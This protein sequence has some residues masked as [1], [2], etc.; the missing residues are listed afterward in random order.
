MKKLI[1]LYYG[2][3]SFIMNSKIKRLIKKEKVD[4]Y[5]VTSYD[6]EE[7][8]I[9]EAINDA[10][11]I[12]FLSD[13][14]IIIIN[15]CTFL[16][17]SYKSKDENE[18]VSLLEYIN[19]PVDST[20]LIFELPS[21]K[22]DKRNKIVKKILDVAA[23]EECKSIEKG[24]LTSWI[25]KQLDRNNLTI[26]KE[27]LNEF[28][29]RTVYDS[30]VAYNE[31]EKLIMYSC[32]MKNITLDMI[33]EVITKN[34]EDDVF[35]I[36]NALMDNDSIK[37]LNVYHDLLEN[38]EDPLKL[39]GIIVNKFKEI[40]TVKTLQNGGYTSSEIATYFKATQGRAY[41]M[42]KNAKSVSYENVCLYLKKLEELDI[43]I[44]KNGIDKKIGL[45]LFLL[46][47]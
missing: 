17:S 33:N 1:Y 18:F 46:S 21:S 37:A 25:K 20:I 16:T 34:L 12:P 45:E 44:K 31:L 2:D 8:N 9:R 36:T 40:Y 47:V 13:N 6:F 39:L 15:N 38:N 24:D 23:V 14:K 27:A 10:L 35:A 42:M 26:S 7:S 4:K 11:T 28:L 22:L 29:R 5:N 41:Y 32:D 3:D 30:R 43:N 19:K